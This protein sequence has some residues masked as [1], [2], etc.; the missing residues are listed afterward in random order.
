MIRIALHTI[1]QT[2]RPDLTP[3]IM[4]ALDVPDIVV[5]GALDGVDASAIPV[6]SV[7]DFPLE[8]RLSDGARVEVGASYLAPLIQQ[9][10]DAEAE[11]DLHLVLCAGPF[12]NLS[13]EAELIRPFEHAVDELGARGLRL[14]LVLV[15]FRA[16]AEPAR[17]KWVGAGFQVV[18]RSMDERPV[19]A[20]ADE[21]LIA[22][23]QEG[24]AAGCDAMILDYVGYPRM[25]LQRVGEGLDIPVIDLGHL[26]TDFARSLID[27]L[28]GLT[29]EDA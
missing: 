28:K 9:R 3:F 10:M 22:V 7:G 12:P 18:V 13:C 2:P 6:P 27:E 29:S 23:G 14:L 20:K 4:A 21:W 8:T 25:I 1:G 24:M 5:T 11:A 26:A 16:Q 17:R 19:D 15:P